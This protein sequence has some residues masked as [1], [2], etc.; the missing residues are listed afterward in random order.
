M[1]SRIIPLWFGA[2]AAALLLA[3]CGGG[4]RTASME[5]DGFAGG[6]QSMAAMAPA[7]PAMEYA[8]DMSSNIVEEQEGGGG[9]PG[10]GGGQ[11]GSPADARQIAYMYFYGFA[12]PTA[13]MESLLKTHQTMCESAGPAVCY[14]SNS[15]ISGLGEEYA[16]GSLQMRASREWIEK[17]RTGMEEGLKPFGA[18]LSST[19]SSAEDL[20]TQIIDTS[21][22]LNSAKTLRDRLQQL[23]ADRPGKLSDLLEIE[24]E[25][26]RVQQQID[27]TASILAAM[28]QRVSMSTLS[29]NYEGKYSAVSQSI[30]RPLGDAFSSF[31]PNIAASLADIVN[32]I[33]SIL[34]WLILLGLVIWFVVWRMGRKPKAAPKPPVAGT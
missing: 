23:L 19:N 4:D 33:S 6:E 10:Q 8:R 31:A 5:K 30:W 12:V 20:T 11:P 21:A 16:S 27:S 22:T 14:V 24:R 29:L 3:A 2:A 17:F 1:K 18:T 15:S 32:F 25:L 28:K 13:Q 26:A 9:Q 34:L 7:P